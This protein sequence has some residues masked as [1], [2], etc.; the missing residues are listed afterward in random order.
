LDLPKKVY[1]ILLSPP[2]FGHVCQSSVFVQSSPPP[3]LCVCH[4]SLYILCHHVTP[5]KRRVRDDDL[6]SLSFRLLCST[7]TKKTTSHHTHYIFYKQRM[8]RE[9]PFQ[10][11]R[12]TLLFKACRV[13]AYSTWTKVG[14]KPGRAAARQTIQILIRLILNWASTHR[15]YNPS[16]PFKDQ[17]NTVYDFVINWE[18][19]PPVLHHLLQVVKKYLG[20]KIQQQQLARIQY[21][22]K[23]HQY[24]SQSRSARTDPSDP[25]GGL[26]FPTSSNESNELESESELEFYNPDVPYDPVCSH[27]KKECAKSCL[28]CIAFRCHHPSPLCRW[29]VTRKTSTRAPTNGFYNQP[30]A[31]FAFLP[32][33]LAKI[34]DEPQEIQE[35]YNDPDNASQSTYSSGQSLSS[36]DSLL[37]IKNGSIKINIHKKPTRESL[38]KRYDEEH[39]EVYMAY[40]TSKKDHE[41]RSAKT[42]EAI[43]TVRYL[44]PFEI[45]YFDFMKKYY[46]DQPVFRG[47]D[48]HFI[49]PPKSWQNRLEVLAKPPNNFYSDMDL[50]IEF[51]N[52]FC[53]R[54]ERNRWREVLEPFAV[55]TTERFI[56]AL[57]FLK[58]TNGVADKVSCGHFTRVV[59]NHP[60]I[61]LDIYKDPKQ[62]AGILRQTSK[63]VKNTVSIIQFIYTSRPVDCLTC[64]PTCHLGSLPL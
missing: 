45:T 12:T 22:F 42:K 17:Q 55:N 20:I 39:A 24:N 44:L 60:A 5:I 56:W 27:C 29:T 23:R 3:F 63:W 15:Y 9:N 62:I 41:Q 25:D 36:L 4:S 35:Q 30:E 43:G 21:N 54:A 1:L 34:Q 53:S 52:K 33:D 59:R 26:S 14:I 13:A 31:P 8:Q 58:S 38:A 48:S 6:F 61:S 37:T 64:H 18:V 19:Y 28:V 16:A 10:V 49:A 47:K 46:I 40:N 11:Y 57:L 32:D 7:T 51:S 50:L 2:I